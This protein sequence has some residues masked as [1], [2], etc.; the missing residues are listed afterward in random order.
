MMADDIDILIPDGIRS[1]EGEGVHGR[2]ALIH[3]I[4]LV[5]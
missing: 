3:T 5:K 4:T 2:E 1:K